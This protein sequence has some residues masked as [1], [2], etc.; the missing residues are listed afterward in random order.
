MTGPMKRP[1]MSGPS[2]PGVQAKRRP[3]SYYTTR[4][5][6]LYGMYMCID[7]PNSSPSPTLPE[8][9]GDYFTVPDPSKAGCRD[10]SATMSKSRCAGTGMM[11][12]ADLIVAAMR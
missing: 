12:D 8:G 4:F 7:I 9:A 5:T 2:R 10:G 6:I 1:T 3:S 11:R